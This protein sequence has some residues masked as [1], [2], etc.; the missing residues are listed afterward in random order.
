VHHP[1]SPVIK[2]GIRHTRKKE[3]KKEGISGI[4]DQNMKDS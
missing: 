1:L 3:K 2:L 4:G